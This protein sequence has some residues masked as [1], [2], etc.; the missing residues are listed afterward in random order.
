MDQHEVLNRFDRHMRRDATPDN[1]AA[2]VEHTG[3]VVRQSGG[4]HDWN[5][6][7]WSDLDEESAPAAVAAQVAHFTALGREFEWKHYSHDRPATLPALLLAAGF[8]AEPAE[9]LMVGEAAALTAPVE[10]P[11]GVRLVPVTDAA[12]VELM[13]S[14]HEQAFGSDGGWLRQRLLAQLTGTPDEV[15]AVVAMAG[16]VP[17]SAARMDLPPGKEF[18]GLWGGG[19]TEAWRGKGVYRA[20]VAYRARIAAARGYPYLQV[21]AS[22]D[23]RPIL[24]RLGF[25][26]LSITTPYVH[27]P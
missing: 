27:K 15:V 21:D 8:V 11:E 2:V 19:T 7:L 4:P 17:V 23:S 20:L 9:A 10:L 6:V 22:D 24:H 3:G 1:S 18:A 26:Q 16:D 14:V 25:V 5:G 13:A 12:G